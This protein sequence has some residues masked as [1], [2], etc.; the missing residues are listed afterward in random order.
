MNNTPVILIYLTG[1]NYALNHAA[2]KSWLEH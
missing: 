2:L 1:I